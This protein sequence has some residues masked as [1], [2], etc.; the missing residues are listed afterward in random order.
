MAIHFI[1]VLNG[2]ITGNHH[3]D[4][5]ADFFGTQYYG[6]ER[7]EVP[8]EAEIYPFDKTEYY[9]KDWK[10]KTETQLIDEGLLPMPQGYIREGDELRRMT[11]GERVIAGL[12]DPQPGYKISNGQ[13]V[14][15]TMPEKVKAGIVSQEEYEQHISAENIAEWKRRLAD[16]Q[17][18][19]ITA[20]EKVD[21]NFAAENKAKL[22][23]LL[24]VENQKGWPFEVKWPK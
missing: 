4:I 20:R 7:V 17:T 11:T 13:L 21:E 16:L 2:V 6:H 19:E 10:R 18:P 24:A 23:A 5:N 15:M 22:I 9:T 12:D 8:G 14:E 1:T 3:G